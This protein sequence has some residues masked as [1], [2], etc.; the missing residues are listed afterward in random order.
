MSIMQPDK[1]FVFGC[2]YRVPVLHG[3]LSRDYVNTLKLSPSFNETSFATEYLSYWQGA[4]DEAWFNFDKMTKYR[5]LKNPET[6][7]IFRANSKQFYLLSVDKLMSL[8]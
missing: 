5:K 3:L 6:H 1:A 2:D 4:S 7:A 8:C